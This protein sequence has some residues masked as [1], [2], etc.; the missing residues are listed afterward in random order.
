M[1]FDLSNNLLTLFF[2]GELN[3]YNSDS[4]EKEIDDV[5][6]ANKFQTL[7]LDF[8]KL[9]Y[10]S[11]AGLRIVLKLKQKYDDTHV[12]NAGL[13]V[14]DVL[15]MTGFTNIMDVKKAIKEMSVDGAEI[16]GEGFFSTV[17]RID[18]DTIIKVFNRTSDEKQIERE[19]KLAKQAFVL[20]I[21]TAISFD[22]VKV[23]DKLGV[24]FEMLDC[25]S[26]KNAFN[27]Y[28][29][30]YEE[31][32]NKYVDL[33]KKINSTECFDP[34]VPNI[35]KFFIEKAE[36]LKGIIDDAHY[37][38]ALELIKN[39][40]DRSTFVHG[41][42]HFKNIMVQ[43]EEFLLIDMDTLSVGHPIF[44][45]ANLRCPYVA[46][47]EDCPGNNEQFFGLSAEYCKKLYDD[48]IRLYFGNE[49]ESIK[50][51]VALVCYIHMV[52]WTLT[53][54]KDNTKRLNGC[55]DR[56][57]ALLDKYNDIDIGI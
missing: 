3:S 9:Q 12:I 8:A 46:F 53:N 57:V 52:W 38:K 37:Q 20:G 41:D 21:P 4:V 34:A 26:L 55:K 7:Y 40:P 10:I 47:E 44:E 49:D 43:G 32:L 45:L 51:K 56:L 33:L 39:V 17:Y 54:Q 19:L 35:K 28:P 16:I 23:K 11:S 42:C 30:K 15:Q 6:S 36:A 1:R 50:G 2:E 29:E 5:V 18:K 27:K 48:I 24:R 31:L 25:M 13:D 14:Y 22:I